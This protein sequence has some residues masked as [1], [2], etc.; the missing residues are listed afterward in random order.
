M[1]FNILASGEV[2]VNNSTLPTVSVNPYI[3]YGGG[4]QKNWDGK[5][6]AFVQTLARSGGRNGITFLLGFRY[7]FN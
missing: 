5:Y 3:E 4:V 2:T 6:S 1:N 7:A